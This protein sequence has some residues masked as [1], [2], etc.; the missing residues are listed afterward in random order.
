MYMARWGY[1]WG[2]LGG[3][4]L[5]MGAIGYVVGVYMW[6]GCGGRVS[7]CVGCA[8]GWGCVPPYTPG[9]APP[10]AHNTCSIGSSKWQAFGVL[11]A[12]AGPATRQHMTPASSGSCMWQQGVESCRLTSIVQGSLQNMCSSQHS[13]STRGKPHTIQ[14]AAFLTPGYH[15]QLLRLCQQ[16]GGGA[17]IHSW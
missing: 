13:W 16:A 3:V 6:W 12:H 5:C 4:W 1:I 9:M 7:V 10:M 2:R 14:P 15:V 8:K 11:V 17:P